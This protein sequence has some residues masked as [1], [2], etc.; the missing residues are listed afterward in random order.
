[1]PFVGEEI[2]GS[3]FGEIEREL[4]ALASLPARN[5]LAVAYL[6]AWGC[7]F[8]HLGRAVIFRREREG[9]PPLRVA[10][11]ALF[12]TQTPKALIETVMQ[13]DVAVIVDPQTLVAG[14]VALPVRQGDRLVARAGAAAAPV[15]TIV[16]NPRHVEI[17]GEVIAI[18]AVARG[19]P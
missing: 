10:T 8:R 13:S 11:F 19:V 6:K 15:L 3:A 7:V 17:A 4:E 16:D 5:G 18:R 12:D 9:A 1:M 2:G 14:G